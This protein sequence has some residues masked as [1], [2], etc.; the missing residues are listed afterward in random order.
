M[1]ITKADF[2]STIHTE[3]LNAITRNDDA[4]ID[5]AIDASI[6]EMKGYLLARYNTDTIFNATGSDRH[7]VVL[8]FCKDIA[9]YHLHCVHNPDKIP[10]VR[11]DRYERVVDWLKQVSSEKINPDLPSALTTNDA[12]AYVHYGSNPK[13]NNHY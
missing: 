5:V 11:I 7:P 8:Q 13:R 4:I 2:E 1:F 9:I 3:I 6:S 12:K 10:Q